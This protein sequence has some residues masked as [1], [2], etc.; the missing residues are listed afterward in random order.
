M[1]R[2]LALLCLAIVLIA[3][4]ATLAWTDAPI[5]RLLAF[6]AA[7]AAVVGIPRTMR[8]DAPE[9]VE[10]DPSGVR[11]LSG[12]KVIES[13]TW[14]RLVRVVI[15]TTD[16]GPFAEDWYWV[17]IADDATGCAVGHTL[18]C[19]VDLLATLQRLP[20]FD[21]SKVLEAAGSTSWNE[22]VCWQG[23]PGVAAHVLSEAGTGR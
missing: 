16:E 8:R 14:S 7:W 21:N 23:H 4:A 9:R 19:D 12:L 3:T 5:L 20:G 11:R 13:I 18:A 1:S 15:M 22:F 6:A 2:R 17:L 10:V